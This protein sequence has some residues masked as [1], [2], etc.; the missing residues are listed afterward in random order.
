M[1]LGPILHDVER[2]IYLTIFWALTL[3]TVVCRGVAITIEMLFTFEKNI[4]HDLYQTV[5]R[6]LIISSFVAI[7]LAECTTAVFLLREFRS[8]LRSMTGPLNSRK[9]LRYLICSTEIRIATL[10]FIGILRAATYSSHAIGSGSA[11]GVTNQLDRFA[12]TLQAQ[13]PV[14]MLQVRP[15][16]S[17][18]HCQRPNLLTKTLLN[19]IDILASRLASAYE[20]K[21]RSN[22]I[23]GALAAPWQYTSTTSTCSP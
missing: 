22:N 13:Y 1:I 18:L 17:T 9:L 6:R 8:T 10:A 12:I 14:V 23:S 5:N 4:S 2:R 3:T 20:S 11:D 15:P 21:A 7:A 16:L 19:S